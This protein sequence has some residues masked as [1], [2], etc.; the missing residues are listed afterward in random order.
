MLDFVG[1][2]FKELFSFIIVV[3]LILVVICGVIMLNNSFWLAL[4]VWIGGFVS[5]ILSAGLVSIFISMK[6]YLYFI[7]DKLDKMSNSSIVSQNNSSISQYNPSPV[8]PPRIN[9]GDKW[10]CKKCS[11]SNPVTSST[12]K[13]CGEYK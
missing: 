9:H 8:I 3:A 13:G 12:C 1:D 7:A 4:F 10:T 11:E 6:E 5:I 2:V